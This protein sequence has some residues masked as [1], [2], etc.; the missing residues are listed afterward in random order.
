MIRP[1]TTGI[2]A[3]N[4]LRAKS[5]WL[6]EQKR[7]LIIL[8]SRLSRSSKSWNSSTMLWVQN[9][10]KA[11]FMPSYHKFEDLLNQVL[12]LNHLL[13]L[14]TPQVQALSVDVNLLKKADLVDSNG[15]RA[16]L[17]LRSQSQRPLMV[18]RV[19]RP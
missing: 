13:E 14:L 16:L 1:I 4:F 11:P 7:T 6:K 17:T 12:E 15:R 10:K 3:K 8:R 2:R 18:L 9:Q 19:Q 5:R